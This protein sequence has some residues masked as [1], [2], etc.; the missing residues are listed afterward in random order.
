MLPL[1]NPRFI[2][3]TMFKEV[4]AASPFED[5][6]YFLERL[7]DIWDTAKG[8]SA[9]DG[10]EYVVSKR[11]PLGIEQPRLYGNRGSGDPPLCPA[12]HAGIGIDGRELLHLRR[13]MREV[14]PRAESDL[15]NLAADVGEKGAPQSGEVVPAH[16]E[17]K[18][19]RKNDA[20]IKTDVPP[21]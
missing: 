19:S 2:T 11:K 3:E 14:E 5:P 13:I 12:A 20:R 1:L 15:Q 8:P 21:P 16:R 18:K 9:D 4:E 10:I 17:I 6:S 7:I